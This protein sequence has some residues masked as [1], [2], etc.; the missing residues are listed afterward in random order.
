MLC[1][2]YDLE[3]I[4]NPLPIVCFSL[5]GDEHEVEFWTVALYYLLREKNRQQDPRYQV[6]WG[7]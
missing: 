2:M 6:S 7:R 1:V 4:V 5:Y 3:Y